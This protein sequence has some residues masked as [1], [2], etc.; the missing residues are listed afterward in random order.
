M[1]PFN[2]FSQRFGGPVMQPGGPMQ[3]PVGAPA[4]GAPGAVAP[5]SQPA[6]APAPVA[7]MP[8]AFANHILQPPSGGGYGVR[9]MMPNA[10]PSPSAGFSTGAPNPFNALR[11]RMGL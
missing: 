3:M 11:M 1:M 9:N 2:A 8:N 10:M 5:V 6:P 4:P 7:P